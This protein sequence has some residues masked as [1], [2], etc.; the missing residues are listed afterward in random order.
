MPSLRTGLQIAAAA[1]V[2]AAVVDKEATATA[3]GRFQFP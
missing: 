2:K 3:N 1:K